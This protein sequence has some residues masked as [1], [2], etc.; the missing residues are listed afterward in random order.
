MGYHDVEEG[1]VSDEPLIPRWY[2]W[3]LAALWLGWLATTAWLG[4]GV[5]V[6]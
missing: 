2:W 1:R 5:W 6:C 3:L 4:M